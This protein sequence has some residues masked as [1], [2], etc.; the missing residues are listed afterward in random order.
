MKRRSMDSQARHGGT[1]VAA[2]L[3]VLGAASACG[4]HADPP[5]IMLI[6]VDTLRADHLSCYGYS[7]ETSP[8]IDRLAREGTILTGAYAASSWTVPSHMTMLTSLPPTLH[9]VDDIGKRLDPARTTL[10]ERL[11]EAGYQTA[12]FVSGPTLHRTFGFDQGF[13]LYENTVTFTEGEFAEGDGTIPLAAVMEQSHTLVTG[14]E[15]SRRVTQWLAQQAHPPFFVFVHL[16]DPHYDYIPTP[17]YDRRFDPDYVGRFDFSHVQSNP[18]L[19]AS[20]PA[21]EL[22]HLVA[23][24]DG[25][26]AATDAVVGQLMASLEAHG[27]LADTLIVLTADHGEE[28]FEHG[29]KGHRKTLFDEVLHVPLIFRWPGVVPAGGR[30]ETIFDAVHLMPT[31]LGLVGVSSGPEARGRDLSALLRGTAAPAPTWAFAE[32]RRGAQRFAARSADHKCLAT[33]LTEEPLTLD[34]SVYDL[35]QDSA[36][37]RPEPVQDSTAPG[38]CAALSAHAREVSA[39]RA[40]LASP[41][42]ASPATLD[43]ATRAQLRALGYITE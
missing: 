29:A 42:G 10:A 17:P 13:D 2:G 27:W 14:P 19:N 20:M 6:S 15:I 22:Q 43:E 11:K 3:L 40:A 32:L 38:V 35:R 8:H 16:W 23:L 18:A 9:G 26:I 39:A 21:R 24:Y 28:F 1:L 30:L 36:E 33:V 5:N 37:Q 4:R 12:A 25:E 41:G 7:Q 31:M 34:V